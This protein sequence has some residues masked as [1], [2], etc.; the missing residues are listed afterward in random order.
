MPPP[1]TTAEPLPDPERIT[2]PEHRSMPRLRSLELGKCKLN[3]YV[4]V[5]V[6]RLADHLVGAGSRNDLVSALVRREA[7]ARGLD[8][9]AIEAEAMA[10]AKREV[11]AE[12]RRVAKAGR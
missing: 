7:A 10:A 1:R 2:Y 12:A 4:D 11:A 8:V 3:L 6:V 5:G 9:E